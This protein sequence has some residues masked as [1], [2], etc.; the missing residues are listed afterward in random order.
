MSGRI[1]GRDQ[2]NHCSPPRGGEQRQA[3]SL[4]FPKRQKI[5]THEI[6]YGSLSYL[7]QQGKPIAESFATGVD[8]VV[9]IDISGSMATTDC[10]N[11]QSRHQV[12]CDELRKLQRQIPGKIAV[13]E[14]ADS[15]AFV[16]GG[17]PGPPAGYTT[18]MAGVL[19]FIHTPLD[20]TDI[21][22]I[23]ISD[24][25]PDDETRTLAEARRFK[26]RIDTIYI[27]PEGGTGAEFLRRLS[28]L[29]G[30]QSVTKS[31]REIVTLE[32]TVTK[33]LA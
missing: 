31:P 5:M 14:W 20:G 28:A 11:Q 9:L 30:G 10:Q 23:L 33:L 8:A 21:K 24:G 4:Q 17:I 3:H 15:H 26:S 2:F 27:G 16:P 22:I 1:L 19:R 6:V 18:D 29:T 7:Q 12:A 25:E 13:I 32:Q